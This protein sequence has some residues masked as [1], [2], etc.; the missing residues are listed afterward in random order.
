MPDFKDILFYTYFCS[1]VLSAIGVKIVS[2]DL[3]DYIEKEVDNIAFYNTLEYKTGLYM[4]TLLIAIF[5]PV[6]NT[7]IALQ[8]IKL[9]RAYAKNLVRKFFT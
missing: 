3:E 9:I 7:S 1:A 8:T 5:V 6:V 4:A 2:K